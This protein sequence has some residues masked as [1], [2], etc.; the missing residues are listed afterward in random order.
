MGHTLFVTSDPLGS[1]PPAL[2]RDD[3]SSTILL[4]LT[5]V[6]DAAEPPQGWRRLK[7]GDLIDAEQLRREFLTFLDAW[8]AR[9][10]PGT[11]FDELVTRDGKYSVWWTSMGSDR[12]VTHGP[13]KYFRC[14]AL[15][16]RAI[17]TC[18]PGSIRLM[19]SDPKIAAL[20]DSRAGHAR[21]AVRPL[22]G[23][24]TGLAVD[25][26]PR[27]FLGAARDALVAAIREPV[28]ALRTQA[29]LRQARLFQ[30]GNRPTVVFAS[31][32]ER[33][34]EI[35]N[36]EFSPGNWI[37]ISR[38]IKA[39]EPAVDFAYLPWKLE[40]IAESGQPERA[41][42]R[43]IDLLKTTAAPLL[44]R[45][46]YAPIRGRFSSMVRQAVGAWRF[47]RLA[48]HDA[49]RRSF[50]FRHADLAPVLLPGLKE[51]IGKTVEWSFK[52]AQFAAALR[53]AGNVKALVLS[54]EV[55]RPSMPLLAAAIDLGIPTIGVQHGTIMPLHTIYRLPPGHVRGA[56]LPDYFAAF[57]EYAK[58]TLTVL[59][60]YPRERV[61]V[62]GAARLDSLVEHPLERDQARKTLGLPID[63]KV[64]VVATQTFPWFASAIHAVLTA[65]CDYPDAVLCFKKHPS[66]RAMSIAAIESMAKT[67]GT[68]DVRSFD[69]E[70]DRLLA[71]SDVWI[72][73]TS[74]TILEAT[75][76]GKTSICVNFTGE[77]DEYPYVDDGASLPAR[78][79]AQLRHSLAAALRQEDPAIGARRK[80]FLDKHAGPTAEGLGATTFARRL[81]DV[82]SGS[83]PKAAGY[84]QVRWT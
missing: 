64:V 82:M 28:R 26:A 35:R 65:M 69:G 56:P 10:C 14:A 48:R 68:P 62:T 83:E 4:E 13:F 84:P 45:E 43:G 7:S 59:G 3:G 9:A 74:T 75:L 78:S 29:A 77:P 30:S 19:T 17:E 37:E 49:F 5:G 44:I 6:Q 40:K 66:D 76:I 11:S 31:R 21:L 55:Y 70:L 81:I 52:R 1:I 33:Y 51:A 18:Q 58:D 80:A 61:W 27:W 12:E 15:L 34:L 63:R 53:A 71:A 32:F 72:S 54:E 41:A 42:L 20:V 67:I 25:V 39:S 24:V 22:P 2:L 16:D 47:L 8:P 73:A 36:G 79:V 60:S 23:C 46:R 57:S 38:A 50:E